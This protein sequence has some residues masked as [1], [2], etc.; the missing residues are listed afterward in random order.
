[1]CIFK[2]PLVQLQERVEV[3]A[4]QRAE[5]LNRVKMVETELKELK[6]PMEQA[7]EFL[8]LENS[9]AVNKN[10]IYQHNM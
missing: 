2:V 4:E 7:I 10:Y 5:K 1:M 3:L 8:K 9:M 6:E